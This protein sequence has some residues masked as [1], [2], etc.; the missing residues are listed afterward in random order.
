MKKLVIVLVLATVLA[1]GTAFADHPEGWGIGVYSTFDHHLF[2]GDLHTF[3]LGLTVKFSGFP[4]FFYFDFSNSFNHIV[5]AGDY[6]FIDNDIG[7]GPWHWYFG[8]GLG[9]ALWGFEK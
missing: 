3:G 1:A 5:A 9:V 8:L 2:A 7:G 6:Y 4:V